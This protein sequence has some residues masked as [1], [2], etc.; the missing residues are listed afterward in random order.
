MTK[1]FVM[2]PCLNEE[3]NILEVLENIPTTIP[4]VADIEILVIDDGSSD[5]TVKIAKEFGVKHFVFHNKARGL[6]TS[7][8]DG[9]NYALEHGA[10]IVVNTDGDNQY[11]SRFIAE[12]V[13]PILEGNAD[14]VIGDRQ[15]QTIQ[16]FSPIKRFLQKLGSKVVSRVAT[17]EIPDAASGFRAYSKESLLKLNVTTSFSYCMETIIQAGAKGMKIVAVP[18]E[19]NKV[20]RPSRL[21]KNT[22]QH[23]SRSSY[24]I[25]RSYLMLRP[26]KLFLALGSLLLVLGLIPAFRFL[27][28]FLNGLG[29]GNIQSLI[30]AAIMLVGAMLCFAIMVIADLLRANRIV[31]EDTNERLKKIQI[32]LSNSDESNTRDDLVSGINID[33]D[34]LINFNLID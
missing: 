28:F 13:K 3:E 16:H 31:L 33:K 19:V 4:G 26:L 34:D 32:K 2:I 8:R 14:I 18:I 23:V 1:L 12:L 22:F 24:A 27:W 6:A 30:F 20:L 9:V 15:T 11:P 17:T 29:N 25:I 10:D 21:F 7:F 5:D